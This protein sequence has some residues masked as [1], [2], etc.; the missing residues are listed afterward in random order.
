M[1]ELHSRAAELLMAIWR[2]MSPA[3]KSRYRAS[4]WQ[5]FED[6]VR[7]AAYTSSLPKFISTICARTASN[8]RAA[9]TAAVEEVL[10]SGSDAAILK[11][12]REETTYLVLLVRVAN[13]Q[14]RSLWR[15]G[16]PEDMPR[17]EWEGM[18]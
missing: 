10:N 9:D 3:Y 8:I 18:E 15:E 13:Q 12:L 14:R 7:S 17:A 11:L 2:G 5:Q 16:G 1:S 6:N 4:I